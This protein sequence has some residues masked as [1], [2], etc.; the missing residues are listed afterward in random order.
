MSRFR[1]RHLLPLLWLL[2]M[3]ASAAELSV[4]VEQG[5][6]NLRI[7][8]LQYP[9]NLPGELTSGLTNRIL[10]RM[11]LRD[12]ATV[13]EQRTAEIA[14]RYD[15]W[16]QS[17]AVATH[18]DGKLQ[19][20][21]FADIKQLDAFLAVLE[22]PGVFAAEPLPDRELTVVAELLLNPI[23]REKLGM[24]RKWVAEN[25]TPQAG[26]DAAA[27][28]HSELFNRIFE[29]YADGA[30]FATSWRVV[31]TSRALRMNTLPHERH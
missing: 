11:S 5:Q 9:A 12:G 31:L 3:P 4:A 16:E 23:G 21:R 27:S 28:G 13:L 26:G 24:I 22:I 2:P 25:S 14:I 20:R 6:V 1:M 7:I 30:Q 29:Q 10:V 8:A 18:V 19:T 15:L 17:F